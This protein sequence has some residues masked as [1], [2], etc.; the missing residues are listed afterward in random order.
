MGVLFMSGFNSCRATLWVVGH[1]RFLQL[2]HT[3]SAKEDEYEGHWQEASNSNDNGTLVGAVCT[4][5]RPRTPQVA[6]GR[7]L[8]TAVL[9]YFQ[10]HFGRQPQEEFDAG[11]TIFVTRCIPKNQT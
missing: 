4:P 8:E 1:S 7:N 5:T 10:F 2:G 9:L 11:C 3:K 6:R